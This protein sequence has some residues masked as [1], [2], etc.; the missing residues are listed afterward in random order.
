MTCPHAP[1]PSPF[2]ASEPLAKAVSLEPPQLGNRPS[3]F[4]LFSW[5]NLSLFSVQNFFPEPLRLFCSASP[6]FVTIL[7]QHSGL[8]HP[9]EAATSDSSAGPLL[10]CVPGKTPECLGYRLPVP[11]R[12]DSALQTQLGQQGNRL[13]HSR[14]SEHLPAQPTG[15]RPMV[16]RTLLSV[17]IL[18]CPFPRI[19][20]QPVNPALTG[21]L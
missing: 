12:L 1:T 21:W 9:L 16:H 3:V 10:R 4:H 17:L 13:T 5:Q 14:H 19:P 18:M 15:H 7:M 11:C 6:P 20:F 2:S 8:P